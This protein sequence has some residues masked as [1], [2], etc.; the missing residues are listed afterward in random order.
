MV[1]SPWNTG[2]CKSTLQRSVSSFLKKHKAIFFSPRLLPHNKRR[3]LEHSCHI[4]GRGLSTDALWM[5]TKATHT[6]TP[7]S[8]FSFLNSFLHSLSSSVCIQHTLNTC[9]GISSRLLVEACRNYLSTSVT[10]YGDVALSKGSSALPLVYQRPR[11]TR[12]ILVFV[13]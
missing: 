3:T 2:H 6:H 4:I 8:H 7:V 10:T 13:E 5:Y 12:P 1:R 11:D 9:M